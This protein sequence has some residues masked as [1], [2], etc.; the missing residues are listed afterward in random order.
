MGNCVA[1][2][3]EPVVTPEEVLNIL[4]IFNDAYTK[5]SKIER[6]RVSLDADSSSNVG[7]ISTVNVT[8][9]RDAKAAV[10]AGQLSLAMSLFV[11]WFSLVEG[12]F[13]LP[14]SSDA[15]DYYMALG[16][17][18]ERNGNIEQALQCYENAALMRETINDDANHG[19]ISACIS[20]KGRCNAA[21]GKLQLAVPYG[22]RALTMAVKV[23]SIEIYTYTRSSG[24][25]PNPNT[26]TNPN[27]NPN[28]N[29]KGIW[30]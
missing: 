9:R 22:T 7:G 4:K 23:S 18:N 12:S 6:R 30:S 24:L 28:T 14:V 17:L 27:T 2:L 26:N 20:G 25:N 13:P 11:E 5:S 8:L 19:S 15:S 3:S 1:Q 29:I 16:D 10:K 21:L